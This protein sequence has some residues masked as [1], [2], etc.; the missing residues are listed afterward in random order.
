MYRLSHESPVCHKEFV[1]AC[2]PPLAASLP[3]TPLDPQKSGFQGC[4]IL[5]GVVLAFQGFGSCC[6]CSGL[7]LFFA[8]GFRVVEGVEV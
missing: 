6:W 8:L 2:S 1:R 7:E 5:F 4:R 3:Y